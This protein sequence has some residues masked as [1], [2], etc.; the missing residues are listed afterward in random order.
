[1]DDRLRDAIATALRKE[2][3]DKTTARKL[4]RELDGKASKE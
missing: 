2:L 1:M 3:I 4:E